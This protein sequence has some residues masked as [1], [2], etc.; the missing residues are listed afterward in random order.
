MIK[1]HDP[2]FI[3]YLLSLIGSVTLETRSAEALR[4]CNTGLQP[5]CRTPSLSAGTYLTIPTPHP[6]KQKLPGTWYTYDSNQGFTNTA[7]SLL[8]D[9][10]GYLWIA[11]YAPGGLC[12]FPTTVFH[13]TKHSESGLAGRIMSGVLKEIPFGGGPC[14]FPFRIFMRIPPVVYGV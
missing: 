1:Y 2:S 11:A 4:R 7:F 10:A 13:K 3:F 8:Q 9:K 5:F 14:P 12:R 6:L